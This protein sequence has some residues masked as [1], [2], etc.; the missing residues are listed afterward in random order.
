MADTNMMLLLSVSALP[1]NHVRFAT[2]CGAAPILR[3]V[4]N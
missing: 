1:D 3:P 2:G 4:Q